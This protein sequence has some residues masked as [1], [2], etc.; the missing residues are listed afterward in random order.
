MYARKNIREELRTVIKRSIPKLGHIGSN[1]IK[2]S[3]PTRNKSKVAMVT[4]GPNWSQTLQS[5]HTNAHTG[6]ENSA[7]HIAK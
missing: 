7:L 5:A 4:D 1:D 3:K 2:C 6:E